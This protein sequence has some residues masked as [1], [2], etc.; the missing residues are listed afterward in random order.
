MPLISTVECPGASFMRRSASGPLAASS[1]APTDT[2][3]HSHQSRSRVNSGRETTLCFRQGSLGRR[4]GGGGLAVEK[5]R[6]EAPR[7]D[8]APIGMDIDGWR[9]GI[10]RDAGLLRF[11]D[12]LVLVEGV[13]GDL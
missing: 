1:S 7:L 5:L 10:E 9:C 2:G 13:D 4:L 6:H 11:E 12:V 8:A 3:R